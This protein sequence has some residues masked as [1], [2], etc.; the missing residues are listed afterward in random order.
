MKNFLKLEIAPNRIFGL[1]LLRTMA[2][3]FVMISHAELQLLQSLKFI[4]KLTTKI[5]LISYS[6]YLLNLSIVTYF[7]MPEIRLNDNIFDYRIAMIINCI[8]Y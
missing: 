3:I 6:L 4:N 2:I 1:D 8:M 5:S 7:V